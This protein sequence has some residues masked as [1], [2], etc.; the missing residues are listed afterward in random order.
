MAVLACVD[1]TARSRLRPCPD[2]RTTL[3][4]P[5]YTGQQV[6]AS[7]PSDSAGRG[8]Q[9]VVH[10]APHL[11]GHDRRPR[12]LAEDLISEETESGVARTRHR[13]LDRSAGPH[14]ALR[15]LDTGLVPLGRNG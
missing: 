5:R 7:C 14:V 9:E 12:R 15:R 8:G 11:L 6:L 2:R 13:L 1:D 3:A 10:R 4:A